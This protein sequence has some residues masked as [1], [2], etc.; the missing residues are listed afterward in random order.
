MRHLRYLMLIL[1]VNACTPESLS[2]EQLNTYLLDQK[3][4][5]IKR[6][7]VN[8]VSIDLVYRPSD[9]VLSSH[10]G[11]NNVDSASLPVM[12]RRY[13]SYLYFVI[14][15][16]KGGQNVLKPD[17]S[18]A[19]YSE[20]VNT[21][22]FQMDRFIFATTGSDTIRV[23]AFQLDRLHE[24]QGPTK[25]LVAFPRDQF[26]EQAFDINLREFGLGTGAQRFRFQFDDI[27]TVPKLR[28]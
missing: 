27:K 2:V 9:I 15:L 17:V 6:T 8:D 10:V 14:S 25:V 5:L 4:G 13:E 11:S 12:R 7:V 21:L 22:S 26:N 18:G 3:N 19:Q 23:E 1:V 20:L 28:L 24:I 16:S